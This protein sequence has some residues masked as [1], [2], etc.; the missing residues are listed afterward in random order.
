MSRVTRFL[1]LLMLSIIGA[2]FFVRLMQDYAPEISH[3]SYHD[4]MLG[5]PM[6]A[7]QLPALQTDAPPL[8]FPLPH[9][10]AYLFNVFASWC[11]ACQIEH[12]E[13]K[14]LKEKTGLPLYGMA[15]KDKPEETHAWLERMGN[16]YDAVGMDPDSVAAIELGLTGAPET[17]LVAADG[18]IAA[19]YRGALS[20]SVIETR[21][22]PVAM[23]QK[24]EAAP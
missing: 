20:Q 13:L 21:F 14:A 6:P 15:W 2:A 19:I 24:Q 4:P 5:K 12:R 3:A 10:G 7:L 11:A 18:T 22:L 17:Y 8:M 23:Q 16:I 9:S 1:P